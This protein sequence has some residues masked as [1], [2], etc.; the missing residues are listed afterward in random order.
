M[1]LAVLDGDQAGVE[2]RPDQDADVNSDDGTGTTPLHVAAAALEDPSL[3]TLLLDRGA[4]VNAKN[5]FDITPLHLAARYNPELAV[6]ALLLD[7]GAD[8]DSR[9]TTNGLRP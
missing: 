1:H 3:A 4:D 2:R 8:V 9:E 6:A 5:D 7:G